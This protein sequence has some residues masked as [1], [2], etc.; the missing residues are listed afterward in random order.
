MLARLPPGL[1]TT[2][3]SSAVRLT[4]RQAGI[5]AL[6]ETFDP[7]CLQVDEEL[8]RC[9]LAPPPPRVLLA[10]MPLIVNTAHRDALAEILPT[11]PSDKQPRPSTGPGPGPGDGD[12]DG[13]RGASPG[14][15]PGD[16]PGA[17]PGDDGAPEVT[18]ET[19]ALPLP[20][21]VLTQLVGLLQPTLDAYPLSSTLAEN[22]L[23]LGYAFV[24]STVC[25]LMRLKLRVKQ[26]LL[27]RGQLRVDVARLQQIY[28]KVNAQTQAL[29]ERV[30]R[31]HAKYEATLGKMQEELQRAR[32]QRLQ[33]LAQAKEAGPGGAQRAS[34]PDSEARMAEIAGLVVFKEGLVQVQQSSLLVKNRWTRMYLVIKGRQ[35][36]LQR[37]RDALFPEAV[38][39]LE[40]AVSFRTREGKHQFGFTSSNGQFILRVQTDE[41]VT[42]WLTA[43]DRAKTAMT[44][45][46]QE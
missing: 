41:E 23:L 1:Q 39:L 46:R 42:E 22:P 7:V 18:P 16:G 21:A 26:R 6:A 4:L 13:A 31:Q 25:R 37:S 15:A 30:K 32:E 43:F 2:A 8:T 19:W 20:D 12:G 40:D 29:V 17:E 24:M 9:M 28:E 14:P 36:I 44:E 10:Q 45:A 3:L 5:E 35:I 33:Q 38:L 11:P 34:G 27:L